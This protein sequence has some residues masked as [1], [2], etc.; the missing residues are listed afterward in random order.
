MAT[1]LHRTITT[2]EEFSIC[3]IQTFSLRDANPE[4]CNA[5]HII[6]DVVLKFILVAYP[7]DPHANCAIQSMM[8]SYN[9]SGEPEDDDELRNVNIPESEGSRGVASPDIPTDL[10][11]QPLRIR[12]VNIGSTE[13]SKFSNVGD[14]WGKEMMVKITNL[15]HEF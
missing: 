3:F 12:K 8:T 4:V 5:L 13:T 14:Y 15:L 9:L 6:H 2:W 10:M 1:E 11:N 7:I